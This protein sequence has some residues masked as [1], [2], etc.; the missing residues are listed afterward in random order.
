MYLSARLL[1]VINIVL[2]GIFLKP[3]FILWIISFFLGR[4]KGDP[5]R[6]GFTWMKVLYPAAFL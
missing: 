4:R 5:A 3:I 1:D 6:I 2:A